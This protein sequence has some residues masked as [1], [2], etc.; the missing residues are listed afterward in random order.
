MNIK[1]T[2]TFLCIFPNF[3]SSSKR[4]FGVRFKNDKICVFLFHN[5]YSFPYKISS[6]VKKKKHKM[7]QLDSKF[8]WGYGIRIDP[9]ICRDVGC[10]PE[11]YLSS[12]KNKICSS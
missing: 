1:F 2:T 11:K 4:L 7:I 6:I 9:S 12:D 10:H 3:N 5:L 8:I